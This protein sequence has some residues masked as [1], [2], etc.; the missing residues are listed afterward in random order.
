MKTKNKIILNNFYKEK[1]KAF[2]LFENNPYSVS[3]RKMSFYNLISEIKINRLSSKN[4]N[5]EMVCSLRGKVIAVKP[6]LGGQELVVANAW[7]EEEKHLEL[8]K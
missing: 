5:K 2:V 1:E 3:T 8:W 7:L 4:F 6:F